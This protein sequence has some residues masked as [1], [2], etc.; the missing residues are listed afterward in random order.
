MNKYYTMVIS[1]VLIIA[2]IF[3]APIEKNDLKAG[4]GNG[5]SAKVEDVTDLIDVLD[6]IATGGSSKDEVNERKAFLDFS[7]NESDDSED[8]QETKKTKKNKY[9]SVTLH[10]ESVLS[11]KYTSGDFT[12]K[13]QTTMDLHRNLTIYMTKNKAYYK[14]SGSISSFKAYHVDDDYVTESAYIFFDIEIYFDK[15]DMFLKINEWD[16]TG[17][18]GFRFSDR[19]LGRWIEFADDMDAEELLAIDLTNRQRLNSIKEYFSEYKDDQFVNRGNVYSIDDENLVDVLSY[20]FGA[21]IT[22]D[23]L[24]NGDFTVDLSNSK[25]PTISL[26]INCNQTVNSAHLESY[27]N[28]TIRFENIDNTVIDSLDNDIN[29]LEIDDLDEFERYVEEVK[30]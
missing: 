6:F 14:S 7:K 21:G 27:A 5:K 1:F 15:S 23:Y 22:E 24:K 19:L 12:S 16:F 4:R 3:F 29:V 30:K 10:N 25:T 2:S 8:E 28:D 11:T 13:D 26:W 17:D 9:S 18:A 20:I